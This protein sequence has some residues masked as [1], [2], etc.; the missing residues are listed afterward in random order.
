MRVIHVITGLGN[1]GAENTLYKVCKYDRNNKHIVISIT[2]KGKYFYILKNI[3]IEVY[4][5]NLKFYSIIKFFELIKLINYLKPE[6]IQTWLII[7]DLLGGIAGRL[8]GYKNIVWNIHF[9]NLKLDSTK[10]RNIIIIKILAILSHLIPKKII[11]VSRDGFKNCKNLGYSKKKL[12]FIPNGYELSI[13]NYNKKQE[14][15]FRKKYKIKKDIPIIGNVSRYDPIKD[16][17][18]LLKG[19]SFVRK[20]KINFLCILVGLNMDKKNK[21]LTSDIDKLNLKKNIKLLGS[22]KNITEIMNGLNAHILTS[23]SEAFPNVVAEAMAC[24]TPCIT[25]NVGDCS[26]IIGKTGW[27]VPP[28]NPI[29]LAK[30]IEIALSEIGTKKWNKRRDQARLRIKRNFHINR[31]IKSFNNLWVNVYTKSLENK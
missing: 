15:F 16:H 10:L 8:A 3:G 4:C 2:T 25:T 22:K 28:Q 12:I 1:G 17:S 9:S 11:I 29:K 24:K 7:G 6:I 31:M 27:L 23:K 20:K 13:F 5:L 21:N 18:T 26:F 19:L 30:V 14:H